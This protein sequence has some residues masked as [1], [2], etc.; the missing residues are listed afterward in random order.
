MIYLIFPVT[1]LAIKF[2]YI[3]D[4][5][6]GQVKITLIVM[7]ALMLRPSCF[8]TRSLTSPYD[9]IITIVLFFW[10]CIHCLYHYKASSL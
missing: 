3:F 8:I 5:I 2:V 1:I 9:S 6:S 4:K 7:L 10:S